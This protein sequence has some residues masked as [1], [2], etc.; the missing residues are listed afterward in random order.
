VAKFID[1][2]SRVAIKLAQAHCLPTGDSKI[3]AADGFVS[4]SGGAAG[5]KNVTGR[6]FRN[7]LLT[8]GNL[9]AGQD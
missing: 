6:D 7:S 1:R 5:N 9:F 3:V 2:R 4:R 8:V